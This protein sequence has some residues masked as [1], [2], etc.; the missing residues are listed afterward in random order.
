MGARALLQ[1]LRIAGSNIRNHFLAKAPSRIH[2]NPTSNSRFATRISRRRQ[3]WSMRRYALAC[4]PR[5]ENQHMVDQ[6]T[7]ENPA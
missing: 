7:H 5:T 6:G 4:F 3:P 2:H 1:F